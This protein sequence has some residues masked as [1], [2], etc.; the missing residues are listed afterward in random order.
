MTWALIGASRACGATRAFH[1]AGSA[2]LIAPV[3]VNPAES[4]VGPVSAHHHGCGM[5]GDTSTAPV[6]PPHRR[7]ETCHNINFGHRA[8]CNRCRTDRKTAAIG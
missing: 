4:D 5:D 6:R 7:C 8:T 2:R 1:I 3:T